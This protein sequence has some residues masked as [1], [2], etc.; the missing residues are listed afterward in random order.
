M[1]LSELE[2]GILARF[3]ENYLEVC[4]DSLAA[5]TVLEKFYTIS[6]VLKLTEYECGRLDHIAFHFARLIRQE[7]YL[8]RR[9]IPYLRYMSI[10]ENYDYISGF[11]FG[12]HSWCFQEAYSFWTS[13]GGRMPQF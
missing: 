10:E 4:A 6:E 2:K 8:G 7:E 13:N 3:F 12:V 11:F 5:N 9:F 1:S